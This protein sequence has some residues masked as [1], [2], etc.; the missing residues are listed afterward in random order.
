MIKAHPAN[1]QKLPLQ[2]PETSDG[3]PI[4]YLW[5]PLWSNSPDCWPPEKSDRYC[6]V[7]PAQKISE[8]G[9]HPVPLKAQLPVWTDGEFGVLGVEA[10]LPGTEWDRRRN[11]SFEWTFMEAAHKLRICGCGGKD[12][13]KVVVTIAVTGLGKAQKMQRL[14]SSGMVSPRAVSYWLALQQ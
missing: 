10:R 2:V 14:T 1:E 6:P 3:E 11:S 9:H 12:L 5:Y 8:V 13:Q 7:M 4:R